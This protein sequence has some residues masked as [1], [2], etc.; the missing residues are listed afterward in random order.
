VSEDAAARSLVF[1]LV[2]SSF[3][4]DFEGRWQVSPCGGGGG[5]ARVEHVLAVKPTMPI[6][7]AIS[8]YTQGIFTRQVSNILR[9]LEREIIK[10]AAAS[11]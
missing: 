6:P 8:Q 5:G 7:A 2:R 1:R 4:R 3:M 9:D 10:Q 11:N